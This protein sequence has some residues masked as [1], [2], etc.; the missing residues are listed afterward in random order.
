M[1]SYE[2]PTSRL[3]MLSK[4]FKRIPSESNERVASQL[5]AF[6]DAQR[7]DKLPKRGSEYFAG[8]VPR[9]F[10]L[11]PSQDLKD[12]DLEKLSRH[13]NFAMQYYDRRSPEIVVRERKQEIE[14]S[15]NKPNRFIDN[16]FPDVISIG[17]LD[18]YMLQLIAVAKTTTARFAFVYYYQI[19]EYAGFYFLDGKAKRELRQLLRDPS[20]VSCSEDKISNIFT[21]LADLNHG[22]D[23]K[24]KKVIEEYC[25]PRVLWKEIENDKDFFATNLAFD[26]GVELIPLVSKD[27]TEDTWATMW[28][29]KLYDHLTRIRNYLV[30]AR[31]RRQ[32]NVILPTAANNIKIARYL[33]VISRLAEQISLNK[34]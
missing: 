16:E 4:G 18:E 25:N 27:T 23:V 14:E 10:F 12:V 1:C 21:F 26:G 2:V 17:C 8:K 19:I 6:R 24:M 9:N 5:F 33:P 28:M 13:I 11:R 7:L 22:D 34:E 15:L 29:P 32:S 20:L 30:H 31:E 3:M